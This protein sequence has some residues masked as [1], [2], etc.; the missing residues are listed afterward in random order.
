VLDF[1]RNG[2]FAPPSYHERRA[3]TRVF[4]EA[5]TVI[6]REIRCHV[7]QSQCSLLPYE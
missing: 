4:P 6:F 2:V 3:Q 1:S 5:E 7:R